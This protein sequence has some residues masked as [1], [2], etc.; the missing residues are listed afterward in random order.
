MQIRVR[1][2]ASE[3]ETSWVRWRVLS[4]LDS[5]YYDNVLTSKE[6][7]DNPAVELVAEVDGTVV[8]LLD[9]EYER[10]PGTVAYKA[11][12]DPRTDLGAVIHHV[13]VHPDFRRQGVAARLLEEAVRELRRLGI[14]FVEAWTRVPGEA[15]HWYEAQG[16]RSIYHYLHV[17]L[18]GVGDHTGVVES[19]VP[20]LVPVYTFAHYGGPD[21]EAVKRRFERVYECHLFRRT[22]WHLG[23]PSVEDGAVRDAQ[24]D[25]ETWGGDR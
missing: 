16:F 3:D 17:Y 15:V 7:Y 5:P 8:G 23:P 6:R 25:T 20:R 13:A 12:S 1:P 19:Q 2:F 14:G 22:I 24:A 10:E 4:F 21:R 11:E 18:N 9:V